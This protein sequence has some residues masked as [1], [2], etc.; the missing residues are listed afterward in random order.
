MN[1]IINKCLLI[2]EPFT[3]HLERIQKCRETGNLNHLFRNEL[4]KAC[5]AH[6]A[7][8]LLIKI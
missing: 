5:L 4:D 1:K 6:E 8:S 3:E 7:Y 2:S